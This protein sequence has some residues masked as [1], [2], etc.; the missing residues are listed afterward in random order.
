MPGFELL[1]VRILLVLLRLQPYAVKYCWERQRTEETAYASNNKLGGCMK[2]I[3]AFDSIKFRKGSA[4]RPDRDWKWW[5]DP[6]KGGGAEV[7]RAQTAGSIQSSIPGAD[8]DVPA[9]QPMFGVAPP[10]YR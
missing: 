7:D 5:E 8:Y 4:Y 2:R 10:I 6:H 1:I 3:K 9:P